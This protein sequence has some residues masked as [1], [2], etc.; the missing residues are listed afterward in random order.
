MTVIDD[1]GP[2]IEQAPATQRRL[3]SADPEG[4]ALFSEPHTAPL[5]EAVL[6]AADAG[7]GTRLLDLGCG[8]GML[9]RLAQERGAEVVGL[10]VS[11]ALLEVAA[12]RLPDVELHV[13]DVQRPPFADAV[14]DAVTAVNVFQFAADPRVAIAEAARVLRPAGRLAIGLFAE[15]ERAESTAIHVRMSALSPGRAAEHAP[16]TLSEGDNLPRAI[17]AAGLTLL[18]RG[19]VVCVWAYDRVDDAV[20]GLMGSAGGTRAVEDAGPEAV[21]G[22]IE[23]AVR[24]F[25]D[26][27]SGRI[28]MRNVFRWLVASKGS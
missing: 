14:F 25:T 12:R 26:H 22:A 1:L 5:F 6:A 3:W 20:R 24:P 16:Y 23:A 8:T 21:R 4:W 19:E 7:P 2:A 11:P 9:L 10:D 27:A 17:E 13:A 18:D 28:A 15:P